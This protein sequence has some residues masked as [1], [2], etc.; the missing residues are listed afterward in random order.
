MMLQEKAKR[1]SRNDRIN[2]DTD[3]RTP[4]SE[5]AESTENAVKMSIRH[6]HK[7]RVVNR[8]RR[9][10]ATSQA[11]W[12]RSDEADGD[13]AAFATGDCLTRRPKKHPD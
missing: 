12:R 13:D 4:R 11:A 6:I 9:G 8:V 10:R 7:K 2:S 3:S 1:L 5:V